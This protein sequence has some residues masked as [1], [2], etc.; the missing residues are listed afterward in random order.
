MAC[1]PDQYGKSCGEAPAIIV[2]PARTKNESADTVL[3]GAP[4]IANAILERCIKGLY[5]HARKDL[6]GLV[7]LVAGCRC[8]RRGL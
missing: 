1:S 2:Q 8:E 7:A 3:I 5:V 6:S 4:I